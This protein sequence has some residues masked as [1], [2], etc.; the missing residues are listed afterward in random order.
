MGYDCTLHV[1]DEDV[2]RGRFVP[3]LLGDTAKESRFDLRED[4]QELWQVCQDSLVGLESGEVSPRDCATTICQLAI[5]HASAELPYHYER[6]FCLSLWE[7][8]EDGF[9]A[10]YPKKHHDNPEPLFSQVVERYPQLKDNFPDAIESNFCPGF[11]IPADKVP[12][13]LKWAEKKVRSFS[14]PNRRLFRGLLLVLQTAAERGLSYWEGT[15][16]PVPMATLRPPESH[17]CSSLEE[18][19]NPE[20]ISMDFRWRDRASFVFAHGIGFPQ[21]CR[22]IHVDIG[23]WPPRVSTVWNEYALSA[24]KSP[25]GRWVTAAMTSDHE[26]LYRARVRESIESAPIELLPPDERKNGLAW[27]G[28]LGEKVVAVLQSVAEYPNWDRGDH[29]PVLTPAVALTEELGQLVPLDSLPPSG[30]QHPY[31]EVI[32]LGNGSHVLVLDKIG[33]EL[34]GDKLESAY[35]LPSKSMGEDSMCFVPYD[36]DAFFYIGEVS[37]QKTEFGYVDGEQGVFL[38]RKEGAADRHLPKI[39]RIRK[40][41]PG[42]N[43]S[44]IIREDYDQRDLGKLYFP[45]DSTYIRLETELFDDEDPASIRSLHYV[46]ECD[47]LI[48][49]TSERIWS[50]PMAEVLALPRYN[51]ATGRKRRT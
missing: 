20:G 48:A 40:L 47:R 15:D 10:K 14:K 44:V 49:V 7:D 33:Y 4:S 30:E 16:L 22:T 46:A 51:A 50:Q 36:A 8:Q 3:H 23:Q 11:Y 43:N 41:T 19:V 25:N 21:D 9:F 29:S 45:D 6:G 38:V 24:A 39:N 12:A 42:P 37:P 5:V 13:A 27:A 2:V 26:Y 18:W 1:I 32:G 28:F 35:R 31:V 17:R 34:A